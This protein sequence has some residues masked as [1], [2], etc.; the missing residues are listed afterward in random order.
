MQATTSF[1]IRLVRLLIA[2]TIIAGAIMLV[3]TRPASALSGNA[4]LLV[5][6][7]PVR[8]A[9]TRPAPLN[10]NVPVGQVGANSSI[11]VPVAGVGGLPAASQISAVALNVTVTNVSG[12]G[13][14]TVYPNVGTPRL[15]L[16]THWR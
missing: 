15:G 12:P 16:E 14:V 5:P 13:F 1:L 2:V 8:I 10:V 9:D 6:V 11:T 4:G 7:G 3:G